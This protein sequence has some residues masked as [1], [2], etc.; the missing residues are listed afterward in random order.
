MPEKQRKEVIQA[1]RD[2]DLVII[3]RHGKNTKD[4]SVR[5]ELLAL[6]PN[7]FA[8]GGDRKL[9]NIPEAEICATINCKM[10][11][12]IGQGGKVESSSWLLKN[13]VE[14]IK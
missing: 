6:R 8:N 7:I 4:M 9:G 11:F 10:V 13:Y 2:V 12:G 14:G 1:M 5:N 3:S